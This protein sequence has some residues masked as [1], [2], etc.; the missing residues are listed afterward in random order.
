MTRQTPQ[1]LQSGS[2]AASADRRLIGALWPGPATSGCAVTPTGGAMTVNIAP[3]S[4]AV[5][6]QNNTGTT[7]CTSDANEQVTLSPAAP[8]GSNRID[9]V[10]CRPRGTDLDG[11]ANNDFIFDVVT[12]TAAATPVAPALPAGT[13]ALASIAVAGG[14]A[15][16]L[17]ANITD[18]RPFGLSVGGT[19]S[20]PPPLFIGQP[21]Q[22]FTD[23]NG[24][25][26][27]AKGNVNAG[28]WKKARDALAAAYRRAAPYTVP[29]TA[30]VFSYDTAESDPYGLYVPASSMFTAPI[31]GL[32]RI[33]AALAATPT[34]T[35][36]WLQTY[37]QLNGTTVS[38]GMTHGSVAV[39]TQAT[40]FYLARLNAGDQITTNGVGQIAMALNVTRGTNHAA[41]AY[42]GTG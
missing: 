8:S 2:Y 36:Q 34:A 12:G 7:L 18:V 11:G 17:Q 27:V 31:A 6:T 15:S 28:A 42:L 38:Y 1:W 5:P 37:L 16:V 26:W 40:V 35:G 32:W 39:W 22:S 25:V 30:T 29:V 10:I 41:F 3:G 24:E 13:V 19:S 9:L 23:D 4:V 20:L 21:F 14:S 33:D